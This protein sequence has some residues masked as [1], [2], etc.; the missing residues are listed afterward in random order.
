MNNANVLSERHFGH[1]IR[2]GKKLVPSHQFGLLTK[3]ACDKAWDLFGPQLRK[4][5]KC[6]TREPQ[7]IQ[8]T[9]HLLFQ[10]VGGCIGVIHINVEEGCEF[11]ASHPFGKLGY[12]SWCCGNANAYGMFLDKLLKNPPKYYCLNHLSSRDAKLFGHFKSSIIGSGDEHTMS[13]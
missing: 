12:D 5:G 9:S 10:I 13:T 4:M 2:P 1:F 8:I 3:S 6:Q 7:H 11:C